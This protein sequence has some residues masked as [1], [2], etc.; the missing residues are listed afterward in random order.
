MEIK[1]VIKYY[2]IKV[3]SSSWT[4]ECASSGCRKSITPDVKLATEFIRG[5]IHNVIKPQM[6]QLSKVME[7]MLNMNMIKVQA[8]RGRTIRLGA[9]GLVYSFKPREESIVTCKEDVEV[10]IFNVQGLR[11]VKANGNS[12]ILTIKITIKCTEVSEDE[13]NAMCSL[14][15]YLPAGILWAEDEKKSVKS[16]AKSSV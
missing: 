5:S 13:M 2:Y 14:K 16:A 10:G 9:G 1:R 8:I 3:E 6:P 15:P 12:Y 7:G 11:E 4:A